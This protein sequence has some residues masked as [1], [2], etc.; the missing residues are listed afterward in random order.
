MTKTIAITDSYRTTFG[1]CEREGFQDQPE[2]VGQLRR[3][4]MDRFVQLGFPTTRMEAW[5]NTSVESIAALEFHLPVEAGP[6]DPRTV[7]LFSLRESF[8]VVVAGGRFMPDLSPHDG[9]P[10]GVEV[11]GLADALANIPE[12][13]L[14]HLTR[15][16]DFS[17]QAFVAL[18]TAFLSDGVFISVPEGTLLKRLIQVIY[19]STTATAPANCSCQ[20]PTITHPRTLVVAGDNSR[21]TVVEH[22]VG[23]SGGVS[24]TGAAGGSTFTNAVTEIAAGAGSIV[25]YVRVQQE[26]EDAGH[27]ATVQIHQEAGSRVGLH[28][29][30]VGGK[31]VRND[32][33]TILAGEGAEVVMN[34]LYLVKGRQ[35]VDNHTRIDHAAPHCTSMENYKGILDDRGHGIFNGRIV[36]RPKAQKTNATQSNQNLMLSDKALVNTNP[37]LEIYADDVKCTHGSAVGQID[38]ETMFYFRSRGI[39]REMARRLLIHGFTQEIISRVENDSVRMSVDELVSRWLPDGQDPMNVS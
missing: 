26:S 10:Q 22:Y 30:T 31:L 8:Q 7:E 36:V 1:Q 23:L 12:E 17:E 4:A 34:G 29:I 21:L 6:V 25:D 18:N 16:A 24:Q 11:R 14:P 13:V 5:R 27:I 3:S 2:A 15:Y 39:D 32:V 37:Q 20:L 33:N 19:L 38:E 9:L 35:H 28:I